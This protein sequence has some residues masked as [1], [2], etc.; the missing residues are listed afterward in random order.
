VRVIVPSRYDDLLEGLLGSLERCQP[1]SSDAVIVA[2]NGLS[3]ALR[4]AWPWVTF[5]PVAREP[6]AYARAINTCV[7]LTHPHDTLVLGD[8]MA[9]QTL[10]WLDSVERFVS[11]WPD[12][13]GAINL[14][15]EPNG[16]AVEESPTAQGLGITLTPRWVWDKVG[17][18]D[19]RYDVGYGY[20][21]MD[22]C[23]QLWHAGLKV[24]TCGAAT[25]FH[26]GSATWQRRLGSY[27]AVIQCCYLS[28]DLFYAKWGMTPPANREIKFIDAA[29]HLARTCGCPGV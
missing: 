24:G 28:H 11:A 23:V 6:F 26:S 14:R 3:P 13:Y 5:V 21:D 20:E 9:M 2:D 29:P 25:V 27:D 4:A 8:D 12:G 15:Q 1:G 17:P 22:Y 10:A 19:E 7:T 16:L 18:W